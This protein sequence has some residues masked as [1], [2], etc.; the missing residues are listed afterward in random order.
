MI[1]KICGNNDTDNDDEICD[2]CKSFIIDDKDL[3]L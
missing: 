3:Q 1:C 2:D